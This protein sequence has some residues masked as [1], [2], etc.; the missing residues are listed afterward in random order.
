MNRVLKLSVVMLLPIISTMSLSTTTCAADLGETPGTYTN[1]RFLSTSGVNV[2]QGFDSVKF[3]ITVDKDPGYSSSVYWSNQFNLVGTASGAYAG[4]QSNGGSARTFLFSAWDTTEARPGSANSYCVTFSGEGEGRSC[5]L[6]LDWQEGHTYQF[7][8]AYS[9]DS[10]LTATV[11]DLS[12]NTSFVLGSIKTSAR[13]ISA[14]GMVNWAEYFEWNSPKATCRS[15]PYSKA[16]FAVPQG[17][18]GNNTITASISSV[19]N[20]TTCSDISRVT[21]ISA[22]SVQ[23][24]AL[25]QSVRGTITNAGACLDI[26]SGLAE[27]NA[28]ITYGCNNG[29]N[30][31]WVRSRTD[32]KLVT[33]DNLCLDGS[34]GIKV[35]S[36]KNAQNNYS[37]WS[38]E[39]GLIR[40]IGNNR[41]IT[42]VG[43]GSDTTLE[44]CVGSDNQKWQVVPL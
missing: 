23:E 40:N 26:K 3:A 8:L 32:K 21:Q 42:A 38:V 29:K 14:N 11:T 16:T 39:N 2:N 41:C 10:W 18:Q 24:N 6:H 13:R 20:S 25:G 44:A 17:T 22:G 1:Y 31:G 9:D 43:R 28:V 12:S 34:S 27:G 30:Q 37:D 4:L 19:S 5:R 35:I 7:T 15:Q 36:C 33:A